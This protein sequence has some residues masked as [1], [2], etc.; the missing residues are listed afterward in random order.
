[1]SDGKYE[2]FVRQRITQLRLEMDVTEHKMSLEL[3]KSGSYIRSITSGAALPSLRE[4]FNI[5]RYFDVSPAEFFAPLQDDGS[6]SHQLCMRIQELDETDM[7]KVSV[8][9]D[10]LGK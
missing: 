10:W 7:E 8:F 2:A 3:G 1:M 6:L 4:L 5:M 9:L